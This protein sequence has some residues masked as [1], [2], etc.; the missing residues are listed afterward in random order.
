MRVAVVGHVE[1]IEFAEVEHVPEP[2]EIVHAE[3]TFPAARRRRR[4]RGGPAREAGGVRHLVHRVRRRRAGPP[5]PNASC[6]SWGRRRVRVPGRAAAAR[7]RHLDGE[8][9]RTI[10][11]LGPRLG[12][13]GDDPLPWERLDEAD[14][15]YLTAGDAEAVRHARRARALV[16]SA[17]ALSHARGL[18]SRARRPRREWEGRR[19]ALPARAARPG[20]AVRGA[21][22]GRRGRQLGDGRTARRAAGS[23]PRC[24][25]RSSTSTAPA[26]ASP[27][28]S[29]MA[30]AS[31]ATSPRP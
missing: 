1:W 11:V 29:P 5:L 25:A 10:T 6:A 20:A 18:G 2:G 23:R 13:S 12:P 19:R 14:A 8:G 22:D 28:G 7:L 27:P 17:R 24:R 30:W 21:D 15:V 16:A 31:T 26:T 3:R 9:E 4:R